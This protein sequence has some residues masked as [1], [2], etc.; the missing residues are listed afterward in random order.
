[1]SYGR[2]DDGQE[3][4]EVEAD[5]KVR[6]WEVWCKRDR[7]RL[8]GG[9][10]LPG[11]GAEPEADPLRLENFFPWPKPCGRSST[12]DTLEPTPEYTLYQDQALE[13]D[14][15]TDRIDV[16]T[17]ALRRR[18]VY[19]AQFKEMLGMLTGKGDNQFVAVND[20]AALMQKGGLE[21][22]ADGDA[23]RRPWSAPSCSS[24]TGARRS[25][26]SSTK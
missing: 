4:T 9:R 26:R 17:S 10:R 13:L 22:V 1:L 12:N 2:Q 19:D 25:S 21:K 24:K 11:V 20:F 8:R 7:S 14:D 16:L 5:G 3:K 6:V 18:G 23:H 15:L